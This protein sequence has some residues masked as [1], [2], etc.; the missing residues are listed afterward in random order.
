MLKRT[1]VG[2]VKAA[3]SPVAR[4]TR[5]ALSWIE[6]EVL[7]QYELRY[8]PVFILGPPRSGTTLIYQAI[9]HCLTVSYLANFAEY[10]QL[11]YSPIIAAKL[12]RFFRLTQD[13]RSTFE[14]YYGRTQG[15]GAPHEGGRLWNRW[16]PVDA[17]Y[18]GRGDLTT[19][20]KR[21]IYQVVA[22]IEHTLDAP[23]VNKN[24][25]HSVR[26]QALVEALPAALFIECRRNQ[27]AVAQSILL[28]RTHDFSGKP[29]LS[30][31]PKEINSIMGKDLL[32]QVCEQ[33]YYIE[34]DIAADR[35]AVGRD[36]FLTVVYEEF[37]KEP[38]RHLGE[39]I[40]FMNERCA[41]VKVR[42]QLPASF[43]AST[44]QRLSDDDYSALRERLAVLYGGKLEEY[45]RR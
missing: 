40:R 18:V 5:Q 15:L 39:I 6:R 21:A 34:R 30:V 24:V 3:G 36:R 42:R 32:D 8:S 33:V 45:G 38:N 14:S 13:R 35:E 27:V 20:Q 37:C 2:I 28:A 31:M 11:E 4:L 16:F 1:A 43:S 10:F 22:G 19:E 44:S 7:P 41:P 12:G 17:H 23:F 29:W 25:K 9:V 26:I